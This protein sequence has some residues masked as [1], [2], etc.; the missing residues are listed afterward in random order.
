MQRFLPRAPAP[1]RLDWGHPYQMSTADSRAKQGHQTTAGAEICTAAAFGK[2]S[3]RLHPH[4]PAI[5]P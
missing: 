1:R 3:T 2:A 4:R 5:Q